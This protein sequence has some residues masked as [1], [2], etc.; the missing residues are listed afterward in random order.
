M[1]ETIE[2]TRLGVFNVQKNPNIIKTTNKRHV[3]LVLYYF[4]P[5]FV[6]AMPR[7]YYFYFQ[8]LK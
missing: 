4:C 8:L 2:Y 7:N 6:S 1:A 3:F 5:S